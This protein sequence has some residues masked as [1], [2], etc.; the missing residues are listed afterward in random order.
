ME[1]SIVM[2]RNSKKQIPKK[3]NNSSNKKVL[4][5]DNDTKYNSVPGLVFTPF[6]V[7]KKIVVSISLLSALLI[8]IFGWKV[9]FE[10]KDLKE[11][12]QFALNIVIV[13]GAMGIAIFA[14]PFNNNVTN[15]NIN[16]KEIILRFIGDIGILISAAIFCYVLSYIVGIIP[17]WSMEIPIFNI[18]VSFPQNIIKTFCILGMVLIANAISQ[19]FATIVAYFNVRD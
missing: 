16:K 19:T 12:S 14:I 13:I 18:A 11:I 15:S 4:Q 9:N 10:A 5:N 17:E 3:M 6:K 8:G 2:S 7:S 1:A